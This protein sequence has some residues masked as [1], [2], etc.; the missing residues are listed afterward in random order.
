MI[1]W[2]VVVQYNGNH[3]CGGAILDSCTILTAAHCLPYSLSGYSV[4]AGSLDKMSS[5]GQVRYFS[6]FFIF[7]L[8]K[9]IAFLIK[10]PKCHQEV[11]S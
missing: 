7:T 5:S 1:P 10:G 6:L 2:Q 11:C 3:I 4:M 8:N 9:V